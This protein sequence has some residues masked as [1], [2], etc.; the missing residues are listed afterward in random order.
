[1]NSRYSCLPAELHYDRPPFDPYG[2]R[3]P[4]VVRSRLNRLLLP[5]LEAFVYNSEI[6]PSFVNNGMRFH[7]TSALRCAVSR[8]HVDMGAPQAFWAM[9]SVPAALDDIAAESARKIFN[10]SLE[11]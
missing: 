1:M 5:A 3:F 11:V 7:E 6:A 2:E 9:V 10:Y 8:V 4:V